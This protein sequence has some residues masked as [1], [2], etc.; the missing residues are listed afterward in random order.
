MFV[1][2]QSYL[3]KHVSVKLYKYIAVTKPKRGYCTGH[4]FLMKANVL[5]E[6]EFV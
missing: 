3:A 2:W 4:N 1:I 6:L 5:C